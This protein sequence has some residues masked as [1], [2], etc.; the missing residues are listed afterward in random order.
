MP[1]PAPSGDIHA[2]D[3]LEVWTPPGRERWPWLRIAV[4]TR[5]GGSSPPPFD[6]LNLGLLSGDQ[7]E[8]VHENRARFRRALGIDGM[9]L[10]ALHQ[11]HGTRV[12]EVPG[13][14][15]DAQGDGLWTRAPGTA[16][17]VGVADCVPIFVW[18]A[19]RRWVGLVHAGWRGS[20]AGVLGTALDALRGAGSDPGDVWVALG[21][22]IGPCCYTVSA[23]V[24][25]RFP[26]ETVREVDAVPHLDLR[27]AN[28]SQALGRGVPPPQV[29]AEV[30]C[31]ACRTELFFSYRR[32]KQ[33]TGR[34]WAVVW[35][36]A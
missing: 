29:L 7:A 4:S 5:R 31:T 21:P 33:R 25:A 20:Q 15:T 13:V 19:R 14:E 10:F 28:R 2:Q 1:D 17:A 27:H 34:M 8:H 12:F 11:V 18:D 6:S 3:G 22:S 23:E 24:A 32:D 35:R 26:A 16:L 36:S 30:P 9:P